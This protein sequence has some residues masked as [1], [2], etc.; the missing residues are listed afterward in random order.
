MQYKTMNFNLDVIITWKW[1]SSLEYGKTDL[2]ELDNWL[3]LKIIKGLFLANR[4]E[5]SFWEVFVKWSFVK[6]SLKGWKTQSSVQQ[7]HMMTVFV[8]QIMHF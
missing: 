5:S 2:E 7:A 8:I 3:H 1:Y 4:Q 6:W